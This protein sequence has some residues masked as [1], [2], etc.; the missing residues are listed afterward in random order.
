MLA[1]HQIEF[2]SSSKERGKEEKQKGP[3][4]S[5]SLNLSMIL[6]GIY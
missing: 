4:C 5:K 3:A 1:D 6:R 2:L